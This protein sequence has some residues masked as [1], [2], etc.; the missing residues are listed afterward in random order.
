MVGEKAF[1]LKLSPLKV[2]RQ[3][4]SKP[5]KREARKKQEPRCTQSNSSLCIL[6]KYMWINEF[7][8]SHWKA[9]AQT[10]IYNYHQLPPPARWSK[11]FLAMDATSPSSKSVDAAE[12][13]P[14]S[15]RDHPALRGPGDC[16]PR[17][18]G[19]WAAWMAGGQGGSSGSICCPSWMPRSAQ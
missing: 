13:E 16:S 9:L 1:K 11:L 15:C 3:R 2:L 19:K 8:T 10:W 4:Y 12:Q 6:P 5:W 18:G 17:A 14:A 7:L